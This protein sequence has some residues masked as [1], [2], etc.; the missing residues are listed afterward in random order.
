MSPTISDF[1]RVVDAYREARGWSDATVST[2]VFRQGRKID[3]LRHGTD[4]T[5]GRLF[6][7]YCWFSNHWP[8]DAVWPADL[9]RY[10]RS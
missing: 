1:L 9:P 10:G 7:A 4:I 2:L 3:E 5:T 6:A 8:D